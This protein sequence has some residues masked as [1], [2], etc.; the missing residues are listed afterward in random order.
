MPIKKKTPTP[1][2]PVPRPRQQAQ[3]LQRC[4]EEALMRCGAG[5]EGFVEATRCGLIAGLRCRVEELASRVS[6]RIDRERAKLEAM[7]PQRALAAINVI[8]T[9]ENAVLTAEVA[10]SSQAHQ[11]Q[12]QP[13]KRK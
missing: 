7:P 1:R 11:P 4:G 3:W 5:R 2:K 10:A 6:A 12:P 9:H 8:V 13:R